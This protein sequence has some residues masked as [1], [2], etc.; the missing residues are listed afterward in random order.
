MEKT[1]YKF[2]AP[3]LKYDTVFVQYRY[4]DRW[5]IFDH[6][7]VREGEI[8]LFEHCQ[9][10]S[11]TGNADIDCACFIAYQELVELENVNVLIPINDQIATAYEYGLV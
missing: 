5:T 3:K 11:Y 1:F 7:W 6:L 10:R 4:G 2:Q 9:L 8:L